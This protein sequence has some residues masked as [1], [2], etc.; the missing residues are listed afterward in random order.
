MKLCFLGL[1]NL[2][3][4]APA[5]RHHNIAGEGVQQTL[6]AKAFAR[7]GCDVRMVTWDLGQPDGAEWDGI[8]VFKA[9]PPQAGMPLVRFLHP[10]WSGLWS[11][12]ERAD[13][14]LYYTS[15]A[16]MHVGLLALFCRRHGRRFVYRSASDTDCDPARLLI[17]YRRDR[18]LYEYGLR[19]AG[20]ILVQSVWQKRTLA[21]HY[22]LAGRV[23]GML[24]APPAPPAARDI[25]VL[26]VSNLRGVKRPDRVLELARSLP[27]LH[28]HMVGGPLP[29]EE[30]LYRQTAQAAAA[31]P[32]VTFHGRVAYHDAPALFARARV[33]LN[34][35]DVEGF[36]NSYLQAW[37]HGVP[38]VTLIDPDHLI[39]RDGL[40]AAAKVPAALAG[41]LRGLLEDP[42]AWRQ[43]HERCLAYMARKH[44]EER[45]L[46]PYL[47]AF[48]DALHRPAGA[49]VPAAEI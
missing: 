15:C 33:F 35:S 4:L 39:Q 37:V 21:R 9:Y 5:Y 26:W 43:A 10:R 12:L 8:R 18:A 14:E 25:D 49:L 48:E 29:G 19:R 30:A 1:E 24:V 7:R 20:A 32:N 2:A 34:T 22:G 27:Q 40:G 17:R 47:A 46:A 44:G 41:A 23:A 11:A 16:G 36:P 31:L 45:V 6:L 3:V 42:T 28:V 13:A 38:V